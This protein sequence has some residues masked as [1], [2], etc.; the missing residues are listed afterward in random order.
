MT[1]KRQLACSLV[2]AVLLVCGCSTM[3]NTEKGVGVGA[4]LGAVTGAIIGSATGHTGAGAAIG[5]GLGGLAGGVTGNSVDE[6]ER[7]QEARLAAAT[8][9]VAGPL[10]LTDIA[11]MAQ[12]H[13]SDDLIVNQIRTTGSVY[14]LSASDINWLKSVGASDAVI[15]EMQATANRVPRRVYSAAPVYVAPQPAVYVVEP[16]PPPVAVGVGFGY[17]HYGR[18]R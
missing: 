11:S 10:G 16:S 6:S 4:G 14:R 12:Q 18:C 9:P 7:R 5:A 15:M 8:A 17:T 3:S 1:T 13:I 2:P